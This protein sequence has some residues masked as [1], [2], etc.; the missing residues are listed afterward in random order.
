MV[1]EKMIIRKAIEKDLPSIVK[2]LAN[3]PLGKKRENYQEPLPVS[4][5]KA[6]SEINADNNNLLMVVEEKDTIIGILQLT[7]IPYLTYQG[8][9]R[10]LI[11]SV[12]IDESYRVKGVGK[13]LIEWAIAK[14][15]EQNCHMV[16]LTTD[17]TRPEALEFYRKLGFIDSHEGLKLHLIDK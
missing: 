7:F 8:G 11:E 16:Q 1:N 3:D 13:K 12:R 9:K 2:L 4:Y 5:R 14:S 10:A 17:K 15:R 6:F